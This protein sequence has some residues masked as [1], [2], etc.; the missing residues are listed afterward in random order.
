MAKLLEIFRAGLYRWRANSQREEL[1][2]HELPTADHRKRV[3]AFNQAFDGT[4]TASRITGDLHA[5]GVEL[6]ESR[7]LKEMQ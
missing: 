6:T 1:T 3:L 7:I 2:E 4:Y 5:H